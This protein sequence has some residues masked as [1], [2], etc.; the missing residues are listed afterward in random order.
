MNGA[1]GKHLSICVF[2]RQDWGLTQ[3]MGH[4]GAVLVSAANPRLFF[5]PVQLIQQRLAAAAAD[6][7]GD[8]DEGEGPAA[9]AAAAAGAAAAAAA[10]AAATCGELQFEDQACTVFAAGSN[11][12]SV[13]LWTSNLARPLLQVSQVNLCPR[14]LRTS[15][16]LSILHLKR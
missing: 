1:D 13:T 15:I 10:A 5:P 11:D 14:C 8:E 3:F 7:A 2:D 16:S 6:E 9:T 12:K 4:K